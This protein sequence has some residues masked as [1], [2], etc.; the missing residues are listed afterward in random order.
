MK[1]APTQPTGG[2]VPMP[3]PLAGHTNSY[4]TYTFDEAL[5]GIAEA[6]YRARRALGRP[7]L[8]RARRPRRAAGRR[9]LEARPLRARAGVAL[10]ALRPDDDGRARPRD[11]GRALGLRLRHPDHQH[12][13]RRPLRRRRRTRVRSSANI[14]ELADAAEAA[15]VDVALEIH[16]DIMA[17]GALTRAAAGAIGAPAHQGRLRHG[18]LRVLRRRQGRRR[19]RRRSPRTWPTCT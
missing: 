12:G 11:Q 7:G 6:G 18:Q 9:S 4:H 10:G 17:S 5:A 3:T 15:G 2:A 16:G 8:D 14:G 13:D 1:A 19:H